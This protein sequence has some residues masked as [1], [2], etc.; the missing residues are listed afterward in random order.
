MSIQYSVQYETER[1]EWNF[2]MVAMCDLKRFSQ[3]N[4]YFYNNNNK[5]KKTHLKK[6]ALKL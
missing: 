1:N 3:Y 2:L 5:L 4:T 6:S